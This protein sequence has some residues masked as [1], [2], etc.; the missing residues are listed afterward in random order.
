MYCHLPALFPFPSP[1]EGG[2]AATG[3]SSAAA[4][5][6]RATSGGRTHA[7]D[8]AGRL[9]SETDFDGRALRYAHDPAGRLVGKENGLGQLIRFEYDVLG[10]V[11][12]KDADGRTPLAGTVSTYAYDAAHNPVGLTLAGRV[13]GSRHFDLDAAGRV[14]GVTARGG[15]RATPTTAPVTRRA[16]SGPPPTRATRPGPHQYRGARSARTSGGAPPASAP[17]LRTSRFVQRDPVA[18]GEGP[19]PSRRQGQG[20]EAH[21][22]PSPPRY[23]YVAGTNA[24]CM[25]S[26]QRS[27]TSGTRWP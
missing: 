5:A 4:A 7:Y 16:P 2:R 19:P 1:P 12:R 13:I 15:P 23:P 21:W 20:Q 3:T 9:V 24:V 27:R 8:S 17:S 11:V 26:R 14:T 6:L 25:I 22:S 18:R 10:Q